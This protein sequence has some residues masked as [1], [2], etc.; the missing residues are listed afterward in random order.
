M[1]GLAG[2]SKQAGRE[3]FKPTPL[4]T[5]QPLGFGSSALILEGILSAK[6]IFLF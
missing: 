2:D 3:L 4:L 1:A 6:C 5:G